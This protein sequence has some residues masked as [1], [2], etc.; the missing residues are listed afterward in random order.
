MQLPNRAC[1]VSGRLMFVGMILDAQV[2]KK[3]NRAC[4]S[5]TLCLKK[6]KK[7]VYCS[8]VNRDGYHGAVP[9]TVYQ[10]HGVNV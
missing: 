5:A 9:L 2:S 1:C 6:I 4:R 10:L 8:S 7:N 3:I